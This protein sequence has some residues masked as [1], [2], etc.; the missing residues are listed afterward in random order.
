MVNLELDRMYDPISRRK[1]EQTEEIL[2]RLVRRTYNPD[3]TGGFFLRARGGPRKV[4]L[5]Y[6]WRPT[7]T[8]STLIT[9]RG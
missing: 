7:S 6:R 1:T 8:R 4:E 5:W 3:G 2:E 9:E